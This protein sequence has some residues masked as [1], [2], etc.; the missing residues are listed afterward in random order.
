MSQSDL[1]HEQEIGEVCGQVDHTA[2]CNHRRLILVKTD[3]VLRRI[4]MDFMDGHTLSTH[5]A[6]FDSKPTTKC[7][8]LKQKL[9]RWHVSV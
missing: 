7:L 4:S 9:Q 3:N 2:L 6:C 8:L 5:F 1:S